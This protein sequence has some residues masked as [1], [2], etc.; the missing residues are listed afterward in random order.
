MLFKNL[1]TLPSPKPDESS[2]HRPIPNSPRYILL[3]LLPSLP[4]VFPLKHACHIS[5]PSHLP[6]SDHLNNAR[7]EGHITM[8]SIS[9][10]SPFSTFPSSLNPVFH[11]AHSSRIP[12]AHDRPL[13]CKTQLHAKQQQHTHT[14]THTHTKRQTFTLGMLCGTVPAAN[15]PRC[16]VA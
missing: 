8:I 4:Y 2:P 6:R 5:R 14:H 13:T 12:S 11:S 15:A 9:L 16:T 10:F 3:V 1:I 7:H